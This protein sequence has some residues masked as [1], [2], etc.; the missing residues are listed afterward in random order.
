MRN[1]LILS[2]FVALG[3]VGCGSVGPEANKLAQEG[4]AGYDKAQALAKAHPAEVEAIKAVLSDLCD[5][6][7]AAH[8]EV[9][10][11]LD[12]IERIVPGIKAHLAGKPCVPSS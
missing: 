8:P 5:K 2:I 6:A 1:L 7:E 11:A 12:A 9:P 4:E 10:L 3:L